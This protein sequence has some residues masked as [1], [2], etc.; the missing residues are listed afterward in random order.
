MAAE[1]ENKYAEKWTVEAARELCERALNVISDDCFY[2]SAV[3]DE[4]EQYPDLFKY[5]ADKFGNDDQVFR[6]IKRMYTKCE[7]IITEKTGKGH[8]TP[9]L[10]IFILK[11]YHGLIETSKQ[12]IDHTTNGKDVQQSIDPNLITKLID[13]L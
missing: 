10:G 4:V 13:K 11:A 6:T 2:I 1:K 7:R 3:A 8:L 12:Q 9:S 5:L